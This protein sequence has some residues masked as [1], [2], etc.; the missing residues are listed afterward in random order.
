VTTVVQRRRDDD[1][2]DDDDEGWQR[3]DQSGEAQEERELGRLTVQ[4]ALKSESRV[5]EGE[6]A[7][8]LASLLSRIPP[9]LSRTPRFATNRAPST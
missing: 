8:G 6:P 1:D 9:T 2:Y 3:Q 7:G 4:A 5:S